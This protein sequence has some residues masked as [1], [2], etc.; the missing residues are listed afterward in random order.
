M[1]KKVDRNVR[2]GDYLYLDGLHMDHFEVFDE[3]GN[4]KSGLNFD[5]TL[6]IDK[7]LKA[8]GRKLH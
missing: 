1:M 5:C 6:N 2:T 3:H 7:L 8:K 4:L